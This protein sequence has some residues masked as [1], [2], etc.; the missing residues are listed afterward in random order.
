MYKSLIYII[1]MMNFFQDNFQV[2]VLLPGRVIGCCPC[3]SE[4][5]LEERYVRNSIQGVGNHTAPQEHGTWWAYSVSFVIFVLSKFT[6]F[7]LLAMTS[8][9]LGL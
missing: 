6:N 9:V 7:P 5:I 4:A 2:I 8:I 1:S 3:G